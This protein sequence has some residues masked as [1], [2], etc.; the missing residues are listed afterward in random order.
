MT[1]AKRI[2]LNSHV[3]ENRIERITDKIKKELNITKSVTLP[4]LILNFEKRYFFM[5]ACPP[6]FIL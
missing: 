5:N 3:M 6:M 1:N 4:A 2:A